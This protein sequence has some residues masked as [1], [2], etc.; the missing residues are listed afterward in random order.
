MQS[1]RIVL[2]DAD[3]PL[4]HL[5]AAELQRYV[6][7][8]FG[9]TPPLS[10]GAAPADGAA[11][12]IIE[13]SPR[14]AQGEQ[15]YW[16]EPETRDGGSVLRLGG[17]SP[18]AALWAAYELIAHWGVHFLVQG[19]VFPDEVRPLSFPQ[20]PVI[21]NPDFPV[22][23]FR[24]INDMA[25]SGVF[26]SLEQH[27]LLFAQLAKL[28]FTGV[29]VSTYPHQ[30]W[31]HYSFGGIER[32]S[33]DLCYGWRH[34]VHA[35]TVGRELFGAVDYHTN[36]DFQGAA[37]YEERLERG[38]RLM[39]GIFG[40][41]HQRGLEVTYVHPTG[42]VPDE[43][44]LR[45]PELSAGVQLPDP[46]IAQ[47]HYSRHGLTYSGGPAAQE[48]YRT[49]LNPVYV[50]LMETSLVAHMEAY[51]DA[52]RYSLS[53]QEFPPGGAG[54]EACWRQLDEK[55]GVESILPLEQI[56][57]RAAQQH[58]YAPGRAL[59]Q[60]MGAIQSLRLYDILINERRVLDHAS[61][62]QARMRV[63]F[64][65]E[66]LQPLVEHILP[67]DRCE[68]MA[69][70]D[71]LPARVAE[72]MDTLAFAKNSAMDVVMITTIED[73]NVGFLPQLVTPALHQ[74]VQKMRQYAIKGFCFR[75]FDISQH[76]P[77]MAYMAEAAWDGTATPDKTYQRYANRVAGAQAAEDLVAALGAVGELTDA[78]NS[79][80]GAG[81]MFPS[82]YHKYW[83]QGAA[84]DPAWRDYIQRLLPIRERLEIALSRC[85]PR[86][87]KL[88]SNYLNFVVFAAQFLEAMD[89]IRQAREVYDQ[90]QEQ[91]TAGDALAFHPLI[92]R[93]ATLL[94][95]AEQASEQALNTWAAQ[96]ADP[97]D[98]GT[99]AGLNAY[100]HDWLRG[101][102]VEVYWESQQYGFAHL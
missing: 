77:S 87:Q 34:P 67:P 5:A 4:H 15:T 72:R 62:S 65:S 33:G 84:P 17:G 41:A 57:A 61:Q 92:T 45:L 100:G 8:L 6:R 14:R 48:K 88:L 28:R 91:K 24:I 29:L 99:L 25:N 7:R 82:L 21:R 85:E 9:F 97:T 78:A 68:F 70:V 64:F 44:A 18:R 36:P 86:G 75:Q 51:P 19:D 94:G 43:F 37:T 74:T 35:G 46:D 71:Y 59:S 56:R 39:R 55:Y 40:A 26:W 98:T 52:E 50:D 11:A 54:V 90:A 30:P 76:E 80:M 79:L 53:E 96:S 10:R 3:A 23:E 58:F 27:K 102:R 63:T 16:L 60:A 89:L 38:Q 73:D 2:R 69:I 32:C 47:A 101:K 95:M 31:A 12:I 93:A 22:R 81:F 49:P 13:G 42:E 1:L 20:A 66:H 83:H